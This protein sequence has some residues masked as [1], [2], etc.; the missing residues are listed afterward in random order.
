MSSITHKGTNLF[1]NKFTNTDEQNLI[2]DLVYESI[3]L[4][5]IDCGYMSFTEDD[6]DDICYF[7]TLLVKIHGHGGLERRVQAL[8]PVWARGPS[9]AHVGA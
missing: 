5:G 6:T 9:L 4:Y 1:F 2:N 3:K 8:G 7:Y